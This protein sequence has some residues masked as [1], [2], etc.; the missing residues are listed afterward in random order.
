MYTVDDEKEYARGETHS[1]PGMVKAGSTA[2]AENHLR[3]M[4]L[5]GSANAVSKWPR[6]LP[7]IGAAYDGT[8]IA[9]RNYIDAARVRSRAP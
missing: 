7:V 4:V 6:Q 9:G 8:L 2:G 3:D 1:E 5:N